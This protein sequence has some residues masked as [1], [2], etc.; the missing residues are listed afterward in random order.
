G[1]GE[2]RVVGLGGGGGELVGRVST[3]GR[4]VVAAPGAHRDPAQLIDTIRRQNVTTLHFVPSMLNV[5]LAHE[6]ARTCTS[7]RRLICSG[8][9]L[10]A[11]TRDQVKALLPDVH[12]ENLYGP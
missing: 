4:L 7:I 11:E 5:F 2:E 9:A 6:G 8:E 3:G 10:S 12:M 1:V